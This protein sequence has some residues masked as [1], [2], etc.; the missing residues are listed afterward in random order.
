MYD[1]WSGQQSKIDRVISATWS[2]IR[3]N[4]LTSTLRAKAAGSCSLGSAVQRKRRALAS[5]TRHRPHDEFG[6]G[7]L[8]LAVPLRLTSRQSRP[9]AVLPKH[10]QLLRLRESPPWIFSLTFCTFNLREM[11]MLAHASSIPPPKL[12][13]SRKDVVISIRPTQ[14]AIQT[15]SLF[16]ISLVLCCL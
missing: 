10:R 14:I 11:E 5:S 2:L 15:P 16:G 1:D 9:P 12:G 6:R 4:S 8:V 3:P 13:P 7:E